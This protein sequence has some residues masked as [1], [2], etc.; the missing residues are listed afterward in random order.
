MS[1]RSA[2]NKDDT[3]EN[4]SWLQTKWIWAD[5]S[6]LFDLCRARE[7]QP[8]GRYVA[9][10]TDFHAYHHGGGGADAPG[11]TRDLPSGS[12]ALSAMGRCHVRIYQRLLH[13]GVKAH[14]GCGTDDFH[15]AGVRAGAGVGV[16]L[17]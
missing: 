14:C 7:A 12:M 11:R 4:N 6:Q 16:A 3:L 13:C 2:A 9:G 15:A 8:S 10:D 17:R 1:T 5:D